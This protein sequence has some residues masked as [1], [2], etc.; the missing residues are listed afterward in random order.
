MNSVA[1]EPDPEREQQEKLE[2]EAS[3]ASPLPPADALSRKLRVF[4]C[5]SSQDKA[6]VRGLYQRL[7]DDDIEAWFDEESLIPGQAWDS[8]IQNAV[9]ASDVV[10]VCLSRSSLTKEGYVQK[11]IWYALEVAKEKPEG[12]IFL[13]PAKLEECKVPDRLK[14]KHWVDLFKDPGYDRLL[15]ALR[16][17]AEAL[18]VVAPAPF[19]PRSVPEILKAAARGNAVLILG[20]LSEERKPLLDALRAE[21]RKPEYNYFPILLDFQPSREHF[22]RETIQ[23]LAGMARFVIA[24]LTDARSVLMELQ[25]IVPNWPSVAVRLIIKRG[26]HQP[27]ILDDIRDYRSVVENTYEYENLEEA[28]ASIKENIITP[29]EAKVKELRQLKELRQPW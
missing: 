10:V 17:R 26:E 3:K 27:G 18:R 4:L 16:I 21:L 1:F 9:R 25:Y 28:I 12:T 22:I 19:E 8:E 20:R 29:A 23:L 6:A 13:I 11:E 5:H 7:S 14:D 24:D 15:K 2:A